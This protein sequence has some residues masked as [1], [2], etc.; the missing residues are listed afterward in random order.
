[1][2]LLDEELKQELAKYDLNEKELKAF[3]SGVEMIDNAMKL[4][5]KESERTVLALLAYM[6]Y[7]AKEKGNN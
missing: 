4:S 6:S 2:S 5:E 3:H 7:T 1:M